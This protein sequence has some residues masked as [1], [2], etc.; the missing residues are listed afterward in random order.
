[1]IGV[2]ENCIFCKIVRGQVPSEQVYEDEHVLGF[3]DIHPNNPGHTLIVPKIHAKNIFDIT[4]N[5]WCALAPAIH[6]LAPAIMRAVEAHGMNITMNNEPAAGQIV[7]HAHIHLIPRFEN[8]G[9][10]LWKGKDSSAEERKT[11]AEKIKSLL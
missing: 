7:F 1:M 9:Y 3:L 10:H 6:K 11:V 2:M 4:E 5:T 8:D